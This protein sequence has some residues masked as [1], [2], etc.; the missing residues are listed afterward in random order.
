[1]GMHFVLTLFLFIVDG[2]LLD[3]AFTT[4]ASFKQTVYFHIKAVKVGLSA[5]CW[6]TVMHSPALYFK[7]KI[8]CTFNYIAFQFQTLTRQ[9]Y[10]RKL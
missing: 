9:T 2:K 10:C 5:V 1:M 7:F 4:L 6:A 8:C 3:F